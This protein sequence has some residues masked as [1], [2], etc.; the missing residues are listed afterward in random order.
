MLMVV[1]NFIHNMN[2]IHNVNGAGT[3][4]AERAAA[5]LGCLIEGA[6]APN[7]WTRTAN[8]L[9]ASVSGFRQAWQRPGRSIAG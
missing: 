6:S 5:L 4:A 1:D 8:C 7:S 9:L 3:Q 2:T